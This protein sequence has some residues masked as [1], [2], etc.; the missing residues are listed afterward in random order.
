MNTFIKWAMRVII[1]IAL[2]LGLI[3]GCYEFEKY[4]VKKKIERKLEEAGGGTA[5][6]NII[7][8]MIKDGRIE[9]R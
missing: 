7:D 4:R 9:L 2:V 8:M 6:L 3:Q 5:Q 1:V